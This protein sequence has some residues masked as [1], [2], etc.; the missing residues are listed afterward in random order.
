MTRYQIIN[1]YSISGIV[2]PLITGTLNLFELQSEIFMVIATALWPT[3][4]I[5]WLVM[6]VENQ[7]IT[8]SIL[9][10]AVFANI[11]VFACFGWVYSK[12]SFSKKVLNYFSIIILYISTY[13]SIWLVVTEI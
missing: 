12:L 7:I 6:G 1:I 9:G 10:L 5:S 2:G 8:N 3:W 4:I 13:L 11:M